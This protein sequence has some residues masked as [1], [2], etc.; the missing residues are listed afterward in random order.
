MSDGRHSRPSHGDVYAAALLLV[1]LILLPGFISWKYPLT[2]ITTVLVYTVTAQSWNLLATCGRISFGHAGFF[3]I[4]AYAASLLMVHAKL[5]VWLALPAGALTAGGTALLVGSLSLRLPGPNFA[6]ATFA[7][8]EVLRS[9]TLNWRSLT[10]GSWGILGIPGLPPP[11]PYYLLW[12]ASGLLLLIQGLIARSPWRLAIAA[13]RQG[14]AKAEALGINT[15]FVKMGL[16]GL[17][18]LFAGL[19]GAVYASLVGTIEPNTAYSL[20]YSILPLV[21]VMFGGIGTLSGPLFGA[22]LL[23]LI[24]IGVVSV[25]VPEAHQFLYA[26]L[27]ILVVLWLPEGVA[28][29]LLTR[30]HVWHSSR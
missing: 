23:S 16:M 5:S 17:S 13:I 1:V 6:L 9:I 12:T 28:G 21:M 15:M 14:E 18:G 30:K 22:V 7:A 2:L 11:I 25:F 24:D 26:L 19:S 8:A 20:S 27:I 4:G 3:G 29:R 10:E